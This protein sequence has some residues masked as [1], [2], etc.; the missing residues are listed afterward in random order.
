MSHQSQTQ[1]NSMVEQTILPHLNGR[2]SLLVA[3]SGGIDSTVLMQALVNLKQQ[4][5]HLQL[6][7][8]YIHH[9]LSANADNWAAHCQQQCQIWQVPLII[10]KVK[11]DRQAG[12]IEEQARNAR[13]QAIYHH[14]HHNETLC[15]AQHLDDQCETFFLALKRG[16]GPTG[17]SAMP[18]ENG[19]HLRPLLTITRA[20]IEAYAKHHQ[21]NWIEDESN[22]DDHYDR[23]F[24]R[25]KVLPHL[26]QRWPHFS[27]MVARSAELCQQQEA[28]INELLLADFKQATTEQGQL[29]LTPL[30]GYSEYKRNAILRMWFRSQQINMPS[31]QQLALIWQTVALA[32]ED[33][34]PQFIL[35][36]KQIRRYQNQLYLL[37][38]YQNIESQMLNWDLTLPLTLPDNVGQLQVNYQPPLPCRLPHADEQVTVRFHAQG[39]LQIVNRKG[40]RAIKKLWQEHHIPP[41]MRTRI[42][43][44]YYNEQLI[45]AVGAF[46][47]EQGK[48]AQIGFKLINNG[49]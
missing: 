46:V 1:I 43:M 26:N 22:Q 10:E 29:C 16:S 14:L 17:L 11:L 5:P 39:Q 8:I 37:P 12:N 13:Y 4:L 21:L 30:F 38:L 40:S 28:L 24:L 20:Q 48:G 44:V 7:A 35:H 32:K 23:N 25:L 31:Q 2:Q 9:G 34:N 42:P 6:R 19:N 45:C 3:F 41:W 27:Q 47:T 49:L 18:I 33:A 36:N 15:T